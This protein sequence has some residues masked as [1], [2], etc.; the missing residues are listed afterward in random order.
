MNFDKPHD[1]QRGHFAYH[2]YREMEKNPSIWLVTC[3]LGFGMFDRIR[4][5]FP[6]RY[7]NVGA[8]EQAGM[9]IAIG[10][11]LSGKVPF[12]YSITPFLLYR[13]FESIRNY[14]N[15]E[16]IPVKLVGG[17]RDQDYMHDGF[18][19][20]AD[21]AEDVLR[22]FPNIVS[23]WPDD[24]SKIESLVEFMVINGVPTFLSL[25]R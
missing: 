8:A 6:D 15:R 5:D 21:E 2:L 20:W 7:V 22:L 1:S 25:R 3:D 11:A 14:I 24:K 9:D 17:G 16:R 23:L 4:D 18:S 10:L 12:I 13:P 19:H